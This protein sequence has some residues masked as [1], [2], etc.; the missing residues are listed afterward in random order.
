MPIVVVASRTLPARVSQWSKN[1]VD[2]VIGLVVAAPFTLVFDL[3]RSVKSAWSGL[4]MTQVC[5]PV[6][7]HERSEVPFAGTVFGLATKMM[8]GLLTCTEHWAL[9]M[10]SGLP[11]PAGAL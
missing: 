1:R 10:L 2:A 9:V 6:V 4:E 5:M 7:S 11:C 3:L 8:L